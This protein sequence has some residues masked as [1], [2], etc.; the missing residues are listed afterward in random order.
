MGIENILTF[1]A[2]SRGRYAAFILGTR[3]AAQ[4]WRERGLRLEGRPTEVALADHRDRKRPDDAAGGVVV[5]VARRRLRRKKGR[6]LIGDLGIVGQCLKA[7]SKAL[8]DIDC[9]PVVSAELEPL[10]SEIG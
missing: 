3:R 4:T 1:N 2:L 5:A 7:V 8:R 9:A 6:D 10:P